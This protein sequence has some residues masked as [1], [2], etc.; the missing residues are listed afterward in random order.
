MRESQLP[1]LVMMLLDYRSMREPDVA[2]R[3]PF[4]AALARSPISFK[5][6]S[7]LAACAV[8][9]SFSANVHTSPARLAMPV[10]VNE[11]TLERRMKS[12]ADRPLVKRAVPAVGRTCD[13]PAA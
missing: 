7:I 4:R 6:T 12:L 13:G 2:R 1:Q 8:R 3:L 11:S 9:P 5:R 10:G